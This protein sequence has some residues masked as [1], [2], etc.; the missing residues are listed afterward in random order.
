M[1]I[2]GIERPVRSRVLRLIERCINE[3]GEV[4]IVPALTLEGWTT[5]LPASFDARTTPRPTPSPR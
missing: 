3:Y 2:E 1:S 5:G 4:L